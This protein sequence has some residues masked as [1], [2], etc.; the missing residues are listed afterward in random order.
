MRNQGLDGKLLVSPP[1]MVAKSAKRFMSMDVLR[2]VA[3]PSQRMKFNPPGCGLPQPRRQGKSSPIATLGA[4]CVIVA[5]EN[6]RLW[7]RRRERIMLEG[8]SPQGSKGGIGSGRG[9]TNHECV[10]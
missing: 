9:L 6:A 3:E 7:G 5:H 8:I 2:K 10:R 4:A 1:A